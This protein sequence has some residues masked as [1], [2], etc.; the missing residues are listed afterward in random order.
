MNAQPL[1]SICVI[2]Y[3]SAS[4]IIETLESLKSQTYKNIEL[5]ISDDFS[6]DNTILTIN[7]WLKENASRFVNTKLLDHKENSGTAIN[8]DYAIKASSGEWIKILAGDD[9]LTENS[10]ESF[11][12][13]SEKTDCK[14]LISN[15][16][17]FTQDDVD[18]S[19][20]DVYYSKLLQ[21]CQRPFKYKKKLISRQLFSAGPSWF[22]S[23]QLYLSLNHTKKEFSMLDEWPLL[24]FVLQNGNDIYGEDLK[25]VKYRISLKS[26]S[27]GKLLNKKLLQQDYHFFLYYRKK[28]ML[29]NFS[30]LNIIDQF[31]NYKIEFKRIKYFEKTGRIKDYKLL[32]FLSPLY[33]LK[34]IKSKIN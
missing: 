1:V 21:K 33:I 11:I 32:R 30:F 2:T 13:M 4:T 10:I 17:A 18:V 7:N 8:L 31:V 22:F 27:H 19:F 6:S 20:Y 25:L 29:K 3:N 12:K 28:Q 9:L 16:Q 15:V 5:I 23:R 24:Y 34:R 14:F 26:L